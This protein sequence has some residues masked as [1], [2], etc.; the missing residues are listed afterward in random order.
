MK[1]F[2]RYDI[3]EKVVVYRSSDPDKDRHGNASI[4]VSGLHIPG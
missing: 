2:F 3:K 1:E 4:K